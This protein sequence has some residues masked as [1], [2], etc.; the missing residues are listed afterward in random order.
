MIKDKTIKCFV[1]YFMRGIFVFILLVFVISES[2]IA[3][4]LIDQVSVRGNKVLDTSMLEL[5][6][7]SKSNALLDRDAVEHDIKELFRMGYFDEVSATVERQGSQTVL[8]FV[9]KEKPAIRSV[10]LVGN[11]DVSNDD[12]KEQLGLGDRRI[13]DERLIREGVQ[14]VKT[15]YQ[16]KGYYGTEITYTVEPADDNAVT[17]AFKVIEGEKKVVREI[18]FEG[19]REMDDDDLEDEIETATY[20]WWRSWITGSGVVKKEKLETDVQRLTQYYLNRGYVDVR[21]TEPV[22]EDVEDGIRVVFKLTEGEE[23]K[24]GKITASGTLLDGGV[25]KV[26]EGVELA[27]GDVFS[28][29]KLRNDTFHISEKYT[30]IGYAFANVERETQIKRETKTVDV[31]FVVNKGELI[32][33]NRVEI[34]GNQKTADNVIRRTMKLQEQDL[35]SSSRITRSKELLERLGYFEEVTITSEPADEK[36]TVDLNVVVR[37]GSTGSFSAGVGISSGDGLIFSTRIAENNLFGTGNSLTFDVSAGTRQEN[38]ILSFNNPRVNDTNWSFGSELLAVDHEYDDFNRSQLGGSLS[39]G[40]PLWF[41]D[42]EAFDDINFSVRYSL[43]EVNI[44]EVDDDA[45]QL[46][47]DEEGKS[48]SS[49]VTPR[50]VRSTIDNPSD[51]TKGSRQDFSVEFAGLGGNEKFWLVSVKNAF[52]LSFPE[53]ISKDIVFAQRT[54]LGWGE[55]YAGDDRFPLF[56]RFF[57]GGIDSVRGFDARE[58]GPSDEEGNEYGGNKQ[59]IG[60][61]ELIFPLFKEIGLK[62]LVFY[63]IGNAFDDSES[64]SIS[65]L[66]QAWGWGIRWKSPL[67]PLRFEVGYPIDKEEGDKSVVTNFSFGTPL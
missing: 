47:K 59:L 27:S 53:L 43:L 16:E 37:E 11:D 19:N 29:E 50:I 13:Y 52:Y 10:T 6:I 34:I 38:F 22:V 20:S 56:R 36:N 25:E 57:P 15:F 7:S 49:S 35:F 39:A 17:I 55:P 44:N 8:V 5:Q 12:F 42:E 31:D 24:V 1:E 65:G 3:E 28:V 18:A 58:M 26:L 30:D 32:H 2:A 64:M 62:G 33:I 51:P 61:F 23:F 40:Y 46:V 9:V 67:A 54:R 41:L 48:T 45:S 14:K 4:T 66:R 63:D 60:N 21:I